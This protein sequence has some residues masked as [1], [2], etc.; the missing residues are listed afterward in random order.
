MSGLVQPVN[1]RTA[2]DVPTPDT[3]ELCITLIA[4]Y[5]NG[6]IRKDDAMGHILEVF[7]ESDVYE[8]AT[9]VQIQTTISTYVRM[10]NQ[11]ESAQEV[12][13]LQGR[14]AWQVWSD[15]AGEDRRGSPASIGSQPKDA[16]AVVEYGIDEPWGS[17]NLEMTPGRR[18]ANKTMFA[19]AR[20][21]DSEINVLT[22]C[23]ELTHKLVQN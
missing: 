4:D 12:V 6:K 18:G 2:S 11:A 17:P 13:A 10:L 8:T 7:K 3:N 9:P 19:W 23:Q 16:G 20:D 22:P 21:K 14:G 15:I 5:L 1:S